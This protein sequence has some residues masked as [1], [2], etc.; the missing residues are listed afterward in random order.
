MIFLLV[1]PLL[2]FAVALTSGMNI[3]VR[4]I[5]P[6]YPFFIVAAAV[7]AIAA[8]RRFYIFRYVLIALLL[9]HAATAVRTAPNY[10]AFANDFWGGTNNGLGLR[11]ENYNPIR[12]RTS[13]NFVFD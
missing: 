3:G 7:G 8:C 13:W 9:F 1:A 6:V 2:F 12:R 5:L 11:L 4:H 10:I